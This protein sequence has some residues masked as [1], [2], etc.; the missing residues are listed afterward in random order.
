MVRVLMGWMRVGDNY[1]T[2]FVYETTEPVLSIFRR[3]FPPRPGFPL[4]ISPI[5]AIVALQLMER[6]IVSLISRF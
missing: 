6:L 3:I 4:D 2:R 1:F 5:F